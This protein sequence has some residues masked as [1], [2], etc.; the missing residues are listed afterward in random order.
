MPTKLTQPFRENPLSA[1]VVALVG[2]CMGMTWQ[3][4][5]ELTKMPSVWALILS[6]EIGAFCIL[7]SWLSF[8]GVFSRLFNRDANSIRRFEAAAHLVLIFYALAAFN[9]VAHMRYIGRQT[10]ILAAVLFVTAKI[11]QILYFALPRKIGASAGFIFFTVA[12]IVILGRAKSYLP[13]SLEYWHDREEVFIENAAPALNGPGAKAVFVNAAGQW[14]HATK[15]K[16]PGVYRFVKNIEQPSRLAVGLLAESAETGGE[17]VIEIIRTNAKPRRMNVQWQES[18]WKDVRFDEIIPPGATELRIIPRSGQMWISD[19]VLTWG[20]DRPNVIFIVIDTLRADHLSCYDYPRRTSPVIDEIAEKGVLFERHRSPSSWS[21]AAMASLFTGLYPRQHG[22]VDFGSLVLP[23]E[24][25]TFPEALKRA[26]YKT[27]GISGNPLLSLKTGFAQGFDR[28]DET[29]FDRVNWRSA[30]C[31]TDSGIEVV[32]EGEPLLLYLQYMDPHL[33]YAAPSPDFMRWRGWP[34]TTGPSGLIKFVTNRYDEMIN[35]SDRQVGRLLDHLASKGLLENSFI[36][37]TA[38]HG[39]ELGD[40]GRFNHGY[41]V[42]EEVVHVPLIISGPGIERGTRVNSLTSGVDIFP[43]LG[44]ETPAYLP[45][46][47][48]LPISGIASREWII[49]DALEQTALI[50][51]K[52]K[53]IADTFH[54]RRLLYD[55]NIDPSESDNLAGR[56]HHLVDKAHRKLQEIIDELDRVKPPRRRS[57][58]VMKQLRNRLRAL[59]Y[60]D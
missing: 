50:T 13:G 17:A 19:P 42:F 10:A 48:L 51:P 8:S 34:A 9:L 4:S 27:V 30:E 31:M 22:C 7:V 33:P 26:G 2:C 38:D 12:T 35:Y 25:E 60:V 11:A 46:K 16:P 24:L 58:A 3:V 59:G 37:I 23:L 53:F 52:Y 41:T 57:Q 20:F 21:T 44:V 28:F 54:G 36:I 47:S 18:G 49:A 29:C 45:G 1:C 15:V 40:H 39:E 14:R 6:A 5:G 56:E 32:G 43:S 55:L